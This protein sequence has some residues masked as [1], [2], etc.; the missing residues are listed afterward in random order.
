MLHRHTAFTELMKEELPKLR[1]MTATWITGSTV[2]EELGK[3]IGNDMFL[4][5]ISLLVYIVVGVA[6]LSKWDRVR[7]R[8]AL[9][10]AGILVTGLG[11]MSGWGW[12]MIFGMP[13]TPL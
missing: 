2:G 8:A 12:G 6:V 13:F 11:L 10:L 4:I 3:A 9:A 1:Y 7:T 5:I